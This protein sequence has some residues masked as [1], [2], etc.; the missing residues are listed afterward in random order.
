MGIW[1]GG[2]SAAQS[3]SPAQSKDLE[4]GGEMP[5][6][7]LVIFY[8]QTLQDG[9]EEKVDDQTISQTTPHTGRETR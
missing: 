9:M 8:R 6:C 4:W 3:S 1:K 7:R 5:S 2:V